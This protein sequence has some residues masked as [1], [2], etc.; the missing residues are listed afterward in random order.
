MI[1]F[2]ICIHYKNF[3]ITNMFNIESQPDMQAH[4]ST[5]KKSIDWEQEKEIGK[6]DYFILRNEVC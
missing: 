2:L 1:F 3:V 5:H 4:T 6:W